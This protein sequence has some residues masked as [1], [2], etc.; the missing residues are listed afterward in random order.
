MKGEILKT[1]TEERS[2]TRRQA[3]G[4]R[5]GETQGGHKCSRYHYTILCAHLN[6]LLR[7]KSIEWLDVG[8]SV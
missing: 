5:A 6:L 8:F 2:A 1:H 3:R 7:V 4:E